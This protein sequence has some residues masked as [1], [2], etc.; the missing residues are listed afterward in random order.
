MQL[1]QSGSDQSFARIVRLPDFSGHAIAAMQHAMRAS[2]P[3]R[4]GGADRDSA[5]QPVPRTALPRPAAAHAARTVRSAG[6][7]RPAIIGARR[8]DRQPAPAGRED[9]PPAGRKAAAALQAQGD[10]RS[11]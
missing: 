11:G 2:Q 5:V 1:Q 6:R 10:G 4:T 8:P 9:F 7:E 3:C